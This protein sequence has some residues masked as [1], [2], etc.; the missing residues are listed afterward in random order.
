LVFLSLLDVTL[1]EWFT[2]KNKF[3]L[4]C[5][6]KEVLVFLKIYVHAIKSIVAPEV[7]LHL[8][9]LT[10][11]SCTSGCEIV[12]FLHFAC[13]RQIICHKVNSLPIAIWVCNSN[14]T[15]KR[16]KPHERAGKKELSYRYS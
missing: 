10:P 5:F 11:S 13:Q 15:A 8:P 3:Y 16:Q 4:A 12:L 7:R 14:A 6:D 2:L 9:L 1:I